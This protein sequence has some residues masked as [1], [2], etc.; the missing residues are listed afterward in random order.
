MPGIQPDDR[1]PQFRCGCRGR[2][3]EDE[4]SL[5]GHRTPMPGAG[6]GLVDGSGIVLDRDR[7]EETSL[8]LPGCPSPRRVGGSRDR[9]LRGSRSR[10]TPLSL[11]SPPPWRR[12]RPRAENRLL[13]TVR[14]TSIAATTGRNP[15]QLPWV[16]GSRC[17][18]Q[19]NRPCRRGCRC[20][21]RTLLGGFSRCLRS[22]FG[23]FHGATI[24][25]RSM[26]CSI[27]HAGS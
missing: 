23:V 2:W 6:R 8:R 10:A 16:E 3:P 19:A 12:S 18:L 13:A 26:Q 7:R 1:D 20:S 27:R 17:P 15:A 21:G 24:P 22:R 14:S 4:L 25:G 11:R 9:P 5:T